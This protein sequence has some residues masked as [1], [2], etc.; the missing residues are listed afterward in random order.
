MSQLHAS[1]LAREVVGLYG[2]PDSNWGIGLELAFDEPVTPI[3]VHARAMAVLRSHPHL[4]HQIDWIPEVTDDEWSGTRALLTGS[5][6]GD[7][8][9]VVRVALGDDGRRLLVAAHHGVCDGLG[10]VALGGSMAARPIS[11]SARGIG[12][13]PPL[14]GFL[15]RS[16]RR[17]LEALV[18]PPPRFVGTPGGVPGVETLQSIRLPLARAGSASLICSIVRQ[19]ASTAGNGTPVIILG[20]SRRQAGIPSPDRRTAYLRMRVPTD[21]TI[22][23]M[24]RLIIECPPEPDFP[25]TT[26]RGVAPRMT[27]LLR[28]RLGATAM[29]S[30]LGRL[31]GNG[32]VAAEMFPSASGPHAIAFGLA[33]TSTTTTLT[34]RTRNDDVAPE[35]S[36]QLLEAVAA[37]WRT[38]PQ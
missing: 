31:E 16:A 23:E 32:L 18:S 15:A 28:A 30:N 24:R 33:S 34:L 7:G 9:A 25:E 22:P 27:R 11:S 8:R 4:G 35:Q 36:L 38:S 26:L 3:E 1:G 14:E 10:L 17:T 6:F 5:P 19:W 21:V 37:A 12:D 2:D 13:R 20:A 29:L